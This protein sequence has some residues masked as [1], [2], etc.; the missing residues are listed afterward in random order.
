M[1]RSKPTETLHVTIERHQKELDNKSPI[2]KSE[3]DPSLVLRSK[4]SENGFPAMH[5]LSHDQLRDRSNSK[6]RNLSFFNFSVFKRTKSD[7]T[8]LKLKAAKA[9]QAKKPLLPNTGTLPKSFGSKARPKLIRS[10]SLTEINGYVFSSLFVLERNPSQWH[11]RRTLQS[12]IDA[13]PPDYIFFEKICTMTFL[14]I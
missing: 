3:S 14:L 4:K 7:G 13:P 1:L 10:R 5:G 6:E 8:E 12:A 11:N 2:G 9:R